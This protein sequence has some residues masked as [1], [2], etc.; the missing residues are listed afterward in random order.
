[1]HRY[2]LLPMLVRADRMVGQI[3]KTSRAGTTKRHG[4]GTARLGLQRTSKSVSIDL[5][6]TLALHHFLHNRPDSLA[7]GAG[8][9]LTVV[10]VMRI[11]LVRQYTPLLLFRLLFSVASTSTL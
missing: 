9:E 2:S 4:K 3:E 1:M 11:T 8:N 10:D 7:L 5:E 6:W